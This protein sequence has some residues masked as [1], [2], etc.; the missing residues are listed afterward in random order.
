VLLIED[1]EDARGAIEGQLSEWGVVC[2]GGINVEEAMGSW[3]VSRVPVDRIIADFRLPG[4]LNGTDV[5]REVR[6]L[7][8]YNPAA[9]L[10]T[11]EIDKAFILSVLPPDTELLQKP[12]NAVALKDALRSRI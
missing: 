6:Q 10:I 12:F 8:G 3:A 4:T 5:I 1:D 7:L 11:G 9:L 2:A